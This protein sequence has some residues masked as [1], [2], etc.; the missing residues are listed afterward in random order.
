MALRKIFELE[1]NSNLRMKHGEINLG[2]QTIPFNA[3]VKVVS[4]VGDKNQITANVSFSNNENKFHK[5]YKFQ[6]SV[7]NGSTNFIQQAY[8]YLKSLPEF[9]GATDC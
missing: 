2:V 8:T 4:V 9:D 6:P 1:G 7:E 5:D 3:Y